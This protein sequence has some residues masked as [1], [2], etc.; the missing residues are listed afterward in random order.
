MEEITRG[1]IIFVENPLQENHGNVCVRNHPAV[2][3]QNNLGN[4]HSSNLIIAYVTSQLKR[5]EMKT[6]VVLQ[7]YSGLK[8]VS[9]VQTEQIA[10]ISRDTDVL[11]VVD[12]LTEEDMKRVDKALL[13]SL[14]LEE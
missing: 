6:H 9:M 10:T 12:H 1:S 4:E 11:A 2:V 13:A 8:K 7:W 5:M 3:I 14:G